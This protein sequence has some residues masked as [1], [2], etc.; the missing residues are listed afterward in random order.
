MRR[1]SE[2]SPVQSEEVKKSCPERTSSSRPLWWAP[3][4]GGTLSSFP[5]LGW[6]LG[7]P[8]AVGLMVVMSI[9]R[10]VSFKL[11]GWL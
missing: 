9:I 8:F 3:C 5:E 10:Y 6:R 4:T 2:S 11:R 7:Y 1:L